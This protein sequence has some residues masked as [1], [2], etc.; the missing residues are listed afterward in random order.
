MFTPRSQ[1]PLNVRRSRRG[2][3]N[4]YAGMA[5]CQAQSVVSATSTSVFARRETAEGTDPTKRPA[6][7]LTPTWADD[8]ADDHKVGL[9]FVNQASALSAEPTIGR[10]STSCTP[11][12]SPVSRSPPQRWLRLYRL[13]AGTSPSHRFRRPRPHNR[14]PILPVSTAMPSS[15]SNRRPDSDRCNLPGAAAPDRTA[16]ATAAPG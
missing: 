2:L 14:P 9:N 5:F 8:M 4:A 10:G 1:R 16:G 12:P 6:I 7:E 13:H 3:D 11:P 15:K